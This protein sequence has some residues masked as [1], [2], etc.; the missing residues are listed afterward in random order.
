[1]IQ[2]DYPNIEYLVIDG[3]SVDGSVQIIQKNADRMAWWV[4]ERDSGQAEAINKG[5]ARSTGEIVAW[6]NSDDIF[7]PGA[8]SQA[9]AAFQN[10]PEAGFV[11]GNA[12]T[13]DAQ[14]RPLN[15]LR[16]P[17]WGLIDLVGFRIICQPAVFIRR[18]PYQQASGLDLDYHFMLDHRLWIK[19]ARNHP[20]FHV[21]QSWAAA[22]HHE[23]A[24]NVAQAEGFAQ[25]TL[26]LLDW[27]KTQPDLEQI[28]EAN[29]ELV[30]A[31]AYRLNARY[32]L[33][34]GLY[35]AALNSYWHAFQ[36]QPGY[37]LK[38]WH[39]IVY[40]LLGM[41][42]FAGA[43]KYYYRFNNKKRSELMSELNSNDWP[44]LSL[45]A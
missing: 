34:G 31:G 3:G 38:H 4:S 18:E 41:L 27:M 2:Q 44:G 14:G 19:I 13:I 22:R 26:R 28:L 33:D 30:T 21:D 42:G 37:A 25:E 39:R 32:L 35:Q 5:I 6:L 36:S 20:I 17:E 9:V 43:D 29:R 45:D 7:L 10:H 11:Y 23:A 12:I 8:I 16:F 24:K 40:A 15:A 1:M